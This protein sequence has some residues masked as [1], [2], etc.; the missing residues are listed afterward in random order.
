MMSLIVLGIVLLLIGVLLRALVADGFAQTA[1]TILAAVGLVLLVVG[2]LFL[3]L[4][5]GDVDVK[6]GVI[7]A[8]GRRW[9]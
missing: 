8:V 4:D 3:L 9:S 5:S 1:G 2:L 7:Y 6:E